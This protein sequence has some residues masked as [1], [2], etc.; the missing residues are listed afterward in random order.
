MAGKKKKQKKGSQK[1]AVFHKLKALICL[2]AFFVVLVAG[3]GAQVSLTTIV[4]RAFL[5]ILAVLVI[6]RVVL[7]IIVTSEE[8][9]SGEG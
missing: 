4:F 9:N 8:M 1:Y 2:I 6:S 3:L 5:V 7:Q